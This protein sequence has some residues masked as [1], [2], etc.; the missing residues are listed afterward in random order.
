MTTRSN[1]HS[2][3]RTVPWRRR[4]APAGCGRTCRG[5]SPRRRGTAESESATGGL[6]RRGV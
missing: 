5:T 6:G 4:R 1:R 3:T 2:L